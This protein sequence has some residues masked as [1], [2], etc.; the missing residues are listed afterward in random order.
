[1]N[2]KTV[3]LSRKYNLGN[4]ET[5]DVG[6]EAELTQVEG[7][8][9]QKILEATKEL[10]KLADTY[11]TMVRF[12]PDKKTAEEKP[13][14]EQPKETPYAVTKFPGHLQEHLSVKNG[15]IYCEFVSREKWGEINEAA[16]QLGYKWVSAGKESRWEKQQ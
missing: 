8:D 12:T 2:V 1:M 6:Y 3:K 9:N 16:K 15:K 7:D 13:V 10:A 5:I 4:Y 14:A 11:Y